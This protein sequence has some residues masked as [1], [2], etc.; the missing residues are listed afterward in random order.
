MLLYELCLWGFSILI[1]AVSISIV[2][3]EK[4]L[5]FQLGFNILIK[6]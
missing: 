5:L 6:Q 4:L 2:A 1:W 3:T